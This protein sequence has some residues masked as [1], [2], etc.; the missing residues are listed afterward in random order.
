MATQPASQSIPSPDDLVATARAMI[1]TLRERSAHTENIRQIPA[2]TVADFK[3][4]GFIRVAQP[5]RFGGYNLG[6]D[7]V[8]RVAVEIGRGCGSSAWMAGQWPGHNFMVGLHTLEVQEEYWSTGADTL[9][10]T[11]SAIARL[12]MEP[13]RGGWRLT[14][15]Q[16]R[17]SSGCDHAE[18]IQLMGQ[19]GIGLIPKSDFEVLDDWYV[20]GL[21]GTGSKSVVIKDSFIPPHR[22]I[23]FETLRKGE[24]PGA[25][26]NENP[27]QR[28]PFVMVVNQ[29]LLSAVVGMA[30]GVIDLFEAR[31]GKRMDL[32]TGRP[33][34]EGAGAQL[35]FA[36][37]TAEADVAAKLL[38]DNCAQ[39]EEWGRNGHQTTTIERVTMRRNTTFA[40]K[41]AVQSALRL[42][43]QG[44]ASGM[45]DSSPTGR[46]VR[47]IQM[48]GLQASLTWD[49]PA[50]AYSR[51]RW[52]VD[53]PISY[54]SG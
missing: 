5:E 28:A 10:S 25:L 23:P 44:D 22:F 31:V 39:L 8:T 13:E 7:T 9:S 20:S 53:G 12:N 18:W 50:Q 30:H 33:S 11:A 1:P 37:S 24:A 27:Y 35:R 54:L 2:E 47:D 46:M 32:H 48:A 34:S 52:G 14:D 3:Q 36:E 38:A 15:T 49:E 4:A 26:V 6:I 41:L 19:H 40:A 43:T 17:F 29:L 42:A 51:V 45:F 21:R 16:L